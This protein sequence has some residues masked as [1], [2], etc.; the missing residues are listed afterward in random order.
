MKSIIGRKMG[1]TQVFAEDGTMYAVTVIEVLPNVVTQVKTVDK[2]GYS[3]LQVG[4][5]DLRESRA[6]KCEKGHFAK[7]NVT[8]KKHLAEIRGDELASYRVGDAISANLFN[9]GEI[10][11]VIGVTKGRGFLGSIQRYGHKIGPKGHGSGYHRGVGSM[12]MNG[13]PN[14]RVLPGKKMA[15]HHGNTGATIFNLIV[16]KVDAEKNYILVK[17]SV[18]GPKK[19][20]VTIRSAF[21]EQL[22][23]K[24]LVKD[25]IKRAPAVEAV[26]EE[27]APSAPAVQDAPA[28]AEVKGE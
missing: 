12:A 4:Y 24:K 9:A 11:D 6:N 21:K 5:E 3:A 17:G 27:A 14:N 16:V 18:P 22:G 19:A 15:G 26:I 13:R 10:V 8:P 2:D 7:A 1:M 20:L 23:E 28:A 25:L